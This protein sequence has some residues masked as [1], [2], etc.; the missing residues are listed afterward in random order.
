MAPELFGRS[1]PVYK[2]DVYALGMTLYEI[3]YGCRPFDGLPPSTIGHIVMSNN[4][5]SLLLD[6]YDGMSLPLL[7]EGT[8]PSPQFSALI[9]DCWDADAAK[10]PKTNGVVS[11]LKDMV[12]DAEQVLE[13]MKTVIRKE[14]R[15]AASM[16][17]HFTN[18]TTGCINSVDNTFS[19]ATTITQGPM[20]STQPSPP[21]DLAATAA[22]S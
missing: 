4:R 11:R 19:I 6:Y 18:T 20:F 12:S 9:A 8:A 15:E 13:L 3:A 7:L 14:A 10:R 1:R 17:A 22:P 21:S 2:T 16:S 5:P